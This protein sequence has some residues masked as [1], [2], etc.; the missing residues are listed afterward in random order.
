ML[1]SQA[2][3]QMADLLRYSGYE[4]I[5]TKTDKLNTEDIAGT[6]S[7]PLFKLLDRKASASLDTSEIPNAAPKLLYSGKQRTPTSLMTLRP[8]TAIAI[9]VARESS[10]RV[11]KDRNIGMG[12]KDSSL[13]SEDVAKASANTRRDTGV[14]DD[15]NTVATFYRRSVLELDGSISLKR[16]SSRTSGPLDPQYDM[17]HWQRSPWSDIRAESQRR[18]STSHTTARHRASSSL[19]THDIQGAAPLA[20]HKWSLRTAPVAGLEADQNVSLKTHDIAGAHSASALFGCNAH[21]PSGHLSVL[22]RSCAPRVPGAA[23][24]GGGG[25]DVLSSTGYGR[26]RAE[27]YGDSAWDVAERLDGGLNNYGC[28]SERLLYTAA[29]EPRARRFVR[30]GNAP[31]SPRSPFLL[32]VCA[33][34]PTRSPTHPLPRG[35]LWLPQSRRRQG[36]GGWG[37]AR[38]M[39]LRLGGDTECHTDS[40][41]KKTG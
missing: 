16:G 39:A 22:D 28:S 23:D 25:G 6:S 1:G 9:S 31:L 37:A 34:S 17:R 21:F 11:S 26:E 19:S 35:Q 15:S 24:A 30:Q 14:V 29:Q 12:V 2:R 36:C 5:Q 3:S 40:D 38:E 18:P 4:Q 20:S 41:A 8:Y 10:L 33:P 32:P 7:A 13:R 27:W